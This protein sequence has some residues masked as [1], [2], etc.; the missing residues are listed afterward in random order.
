M[1]QLPCLERINRIDQHQYFQ[2]QAVS[3]PDEQHYLCYRKTHNRSTES[4]PLCDQES[5]S[6]RGH[7]AKRVGYGV[8]KISQGRCRFTITLN[9][10][11]SILKHLPNRF[12]QDCDK[13]LPELRH[14]RE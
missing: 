4:Q 12:K 8:A 2:E 14:S 10:E 5:N 1:P 3:N 13:E 6:T 9:G 7:I 11:L